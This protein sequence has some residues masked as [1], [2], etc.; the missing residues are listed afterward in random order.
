[1]CLNGEGWSRVRTRQQKIVRI[2]VV[3]AVIVAI[4]AGTAYLSANAGFRHELTL[5]TTR[6]PEPLTELYFAQPANLPRSATAGQQLPVSFV[7]HNMESHDMTYSYK[8]TLRTANG[9]ETEATHADVPVS[10]GQSKIVTDTITIPAFQTML[11]VNVTVINKGQ[12]IHFWLERHG[13]S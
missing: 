3:T 9:D 6:Q 13:G 5:A 11:Q 7:I 1:M 2:T 10:D 12:S 4:A 8:V